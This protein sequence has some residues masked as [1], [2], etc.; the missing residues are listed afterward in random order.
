MNFHP[1]KVKT[2]CGD[3]AS[4]KSESIYSV[5]EKNYKLEISNNPD[6][7]FIAP[8][9]YTKISYR[10]SVRIL[11]SYENC[12]PD[13]NIFDYAITIFPDFKYSNRHL[14]LPC[15]CQHGQVGAQI[16]KW[17]MSKH[18]DNENELAN[19]IGFCSFL[20]S[21]QGFGSNRKRVDFFKY[22]SNYKKIDSGGRFMN[23]IGKPVDD[24]IEFARKY[25]FAISFENSSHY[26]TER[27]QDAFAAK[28]IPIFWGD[29]EIGKI[30]NTKAF[31]NC[32]DYKNF[33]EVIE[34]IQQIDND[35]VLYMSMLNEPA[36][37]YPKSYEE[38]LKE[39]EEFLMNIIETPKEI[40]MQRDSVSGPHII[41]EATKNFSMRLFPIAVAIIRFL[42]PFMRITSHLRMILTKN[43]LKDNDTQKKIL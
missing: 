14:Y 26:N 43:R 2:S 34:K 23:N 29:P 32:H 38:Y 41:A 19:K 16:H 20:V 25:K 35:D 17:S 22:L 3:D 13:Y 30:Y 8:N 5:L 21:A 42:R 1:N 9:Y 12:K 18:I 28:T 15:T 6:Y 7:V 11:I 33:D 24:K 36:Y 37:L 39:L 27:I 10:N 31:I 40:A 4:L